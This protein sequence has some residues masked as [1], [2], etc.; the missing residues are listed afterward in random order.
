VTAV[1]CALY[2][3]LSPEPM[4]MSEEECGYGLT[5]KKRR[6]CSDGCRKRYER[7]APEQL[8][9]KFAG[10]APLVMRLV[11]RCSFELAEESG[12][13]PSKVGVEAR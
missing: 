12:R 11:M 2:L 13:H 1:L 6:W 5:G 4:R 8:G 9:L 7:R 10:D 3:D